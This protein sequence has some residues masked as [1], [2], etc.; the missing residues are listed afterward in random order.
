MFINLLITFCSLL[1][2]IQDTCQYKLKTEKVSSFFS[3]IFTFLFFCFLYFFVSFFFS[4]S[5]FFLHL[6]PSFSVAL[7]SS[8][9]SFSIFF[10]KTRALQSFIFFAFSFFSPF[11]L[12]LL[13][14]LFSSSSSSLLLP[15]FPPC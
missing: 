3:I 6:L 12:F 2:G 1:W 9:S 11:V 13:S 8:S 14:C 10:H 7:Q 4:L 5:F 15:P